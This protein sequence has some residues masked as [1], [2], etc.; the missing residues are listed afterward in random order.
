SAVVGVAP[1]VLDAI[2][3]GRRA[4]WLNVLEALQYE[5]RQ[6]DSNSVER[7]GRSPVECS[8][9]LRRR[10]PLLAED[11]VGGAH[12]LL[13]AGPLR[14]PLELLVAPDLQVLEGKRER[15]QLP[16]RVRMALEERAPVERAE[17]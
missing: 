2:L 3:P 16:G 15:G 5:E 1:G 11:R 6:G 10:R 12:R 9:E 8:C 4:A 13:V 14:H 7:R 17:P